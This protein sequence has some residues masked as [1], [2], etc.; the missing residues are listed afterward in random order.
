MGVA[1][2]LELPPQQYEQ[3]A[4]VAQTRQLSV[5][6]VVQQVLEDC[7]G[8]QAQIEHARALMCELS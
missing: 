7:L 5:A 3:L 8:R 4:S 6:A 1:I 2:E